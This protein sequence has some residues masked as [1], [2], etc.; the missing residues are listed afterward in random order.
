M[1]R[2]TGRVAQKV[3]PARPDKGR[4]AALRSAA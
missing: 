2:H 4:G 1:R 3:T